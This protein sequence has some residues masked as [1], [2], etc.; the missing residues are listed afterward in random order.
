MALPRIWG[1]GLTIGAVAA[2]AAALA[3][4]APATAGSPA[5]P[6]FT[7]HR[8]INY[9]PAT[10]LGARALAGKAT[11]KLQTFTA[12]QT[13]GKKTFSFT[14]V[15]KNPRVK[16][17]K[18]S[19]TINAELIPVDFK[20]NGLTNDAT[21]GNSCDSTPA[22][23]RAMNSP[24]VKNV[25]WTFGKKSMGT[26]QYTDAFQRAEFYKFTK[27]GAVNPNYHVK[28]AYKL[29]PKVTINVP[30]ADGA[31]AQLSC[32]SNS[33]ELAVEINWLDGYLQSTVLPSLASQGLIGPNTFPMFLSTNTVEYI[34]TTANCCVLGFHNAYQASNG[35]Q[36]YG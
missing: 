5:L 20:W 32:S 19:S 9:Q 24:I 3:V 4:A 6:H 33:Y 28:L 25:S 2:S 13:D 26:T 21:I 31:Y 14:M 7:P 27:P 10:H 18:P 12:K 1:A 8:V 23:T 22:T 30:A 11:V 16:Q 34:Q 17:S 35:V 36:T 29:L 15:G